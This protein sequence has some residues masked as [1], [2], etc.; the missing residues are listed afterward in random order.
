MCE[1]SDSDLDDLWRMTQK[2]LP[3]K[4]VQPDILIGTKHLYKVGFTPAGRHIRS[5]SNV[6][7]TGL[8]PVITGHG[9]MVTNLKAVESCNLVLQ[10]DKAEAEYHHGS[11]PKNIHFGEPYVQHSSGAA[12][13]SLS[14]V[15]TDMGL[16][17]TTSAAAGRV[18]S[19][20]ESH[21]KERHCNV[22]GPEKT[23]A[24]TDISA[25]GTDLPVDQ[26]TGFPSFPPETPLGR[27]C[28]RDVMAKSFTENEV[29]DLVARRPLQM[30]LVRW[31]GWL[32]SRPG[33]AAFEF[34]RE[35]LRGVRVYQSIWTYEKH[36][37]FH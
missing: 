16:D 15:E 1:T 23:E 30:I 29:E 26:N 21:V 33:P 17:Q 24:S 12:L 10:D 7:K 35:L 4:T 3:T 20:Y 36:G 28:V 14:P 27:N 19:P 25:S 8:G 18:P 31:V 5:G 9:K 11:E 32:I 2:Y 13:D 22:A 6:V 37:S 34:L